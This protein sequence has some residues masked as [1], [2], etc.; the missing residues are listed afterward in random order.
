ME[1]PPTCLQGLNKQEKINKIFNSMD[2][3]K[4]A[5]ENVDQAT[6][7]FIIILNIL[8]YKQYLF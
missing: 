7:S 5:R 1:C 4:Q 3:E 6:V 2:Y 8:Y